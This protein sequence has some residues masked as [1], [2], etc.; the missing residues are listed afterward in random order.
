[1]SGVEVGTAITTSSGVVGDVYRGLKDASLQV[2]RWMARKEGLAVLKKLPTGFQAMVFGV[3]LSPELMAALALGGRP[4]I[5]L[6]TLAL[7]HTTSWGLRESHNFQSYLA[8]LLEDTP[9]P[10][11][12]DV[13]EETRMNDS[14]HEFELL[15]GQPDREL[16]VSRPSQQPASCLEASGTLAVVGAVFA[17]V[18][19]TRGLIVYDSGP[20][21][22]WY[23]EN[24]FGKL[25]LSAVDTCPNPNDNSID[26]SATNDGSQVFSVKAAT[27]ASYAEFYR[28]FGLIEEKK[29]AGVLELLGLEKVA[30][31]LGSDFASKITGGDCDLLSKS[32]LRK[33][34]GLEGEY[35]PLQ[36]A[37]DIKSLVTKEVQA[38]HLSDREY[39]KT[40]FGSIKDT[41]TEF[42]HEVAGRANRR[43]NVGCRPYDES[44]VSLLVKSCVLDALEEPRVFAIFDGFKKSKV[45]IAVS[46]GSMAVF[47][48]GLNLTVAFPEGS[49][50]DL[51]SASRCRAACPFLP[52]LSLTLPILVHLA[53]KIC[54][55]HAEKGR[56]SKVAK[57]LSRY[58]GAD[59]AFALSPLSEDVLRSFSTTEV[60]TYLLSDLFSVKP[61]T[62]RHSE[63]AVGGVLSQLGVEFIVPPGVAGSDVRCYFDR[64]RDLGWGRCRGTVGEVVVDCRVNIEHCMIHHT[65]HGTFLGTEEPGDEGTDDKMVAKITGA[66]AS[67]LM[68]DCLEGEKNLLVEICS[69]ALT[70]AMPRPISLKC[71][72][73]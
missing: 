21:C 4:G 9:T 19:S 64:C 6:S 23:C 30:K 15:D 38:L 68:E 63:A 36:I 24:R 56:L 8:L 45:N 58:L 46:S 29:A 12:K 71:Y 27:L 32:F 7:M 11:P 40:R 43:G 42:L 50:R 55:K 31:D 69:E 66:L 67:K 14:L 48:P 17:S 28:I 33:M 10:Q 41:I 59:P 72:V 25:E 60:P 1:M 20:G 49:S 62:E 44:D 37:N 51:K 73:G 16:R 54:E 35:G 5:K 13:Q 61:G 3:D 52:D 39:E 70:F 26:V 53:P 18:H 22:F 34:Q 57:A 65:D 2:R 47:F